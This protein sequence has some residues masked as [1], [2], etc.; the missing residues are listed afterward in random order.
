MSTDENCVYDRAASPLPD[1]PQSHI[2]VRAF[3][4][5]LKD[6]TSSLRA[7]QSNADLGDIALNLSKLYRCIGACSSETRRDLLNV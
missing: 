7:E 1:L 2:P 6:E 4:K 5:H 3:V